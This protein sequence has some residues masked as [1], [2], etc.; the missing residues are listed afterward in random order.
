MN[1]AVSE[2]CL[3]KF[4]TRQFLR[5]ICYQPSISEIDSF[6]D[7]KKLSAIFANSP[8][9]LKAPDSSGSRGFQAFDEIGK[10]TERD[11]QY[12]KQFSKSGKVIVEAK[13]ERTEK[14]ISEISVEALWHDGECKVTNIVDRVFIHDALQY[15]SLDFITGDVKSPGIEVG[16]FNPSFL[17]SSK[18]DD[19]RILY[20]NI[21]ES[22]PMAEGLRSLKLDLLIDENDQVVVLEMTPRSSGGWDSCFSNIA[23]GGNV[24]RVF[25]DYCLGRISEKLAYDEAV[26]A[27]RLLSRSFV[28][29]IPEADASNCIGRVF[30]NSEVFGLDASPEIIVASA[31]EKFKKGEK[32]ET[33]PIR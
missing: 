11:V 29:G 22:L 25:L 6:S 5:D 2:I 28:L 21:F 15:K 20:N 19:I 24:Q 8:V 16:H 32:L 30:Y 14:L 1:G 10:I 13:L 3:D 31:V 4:K 26:A 17:P 18:M 12:T 23:I 27:S 9:V 7:I 33:L